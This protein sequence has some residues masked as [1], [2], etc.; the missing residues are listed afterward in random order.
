[1]GR[2]ATTRILEGVRIG[3]HVVDGHRLGG[4]GPPTDV[5]LQRGRVDVDLG[6]EDRTVFGG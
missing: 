6:I 5:R 1:M 4:V 3:H 2:L